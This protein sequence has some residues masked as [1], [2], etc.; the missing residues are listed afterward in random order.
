M[1]I[2]LSPETQKLLEERMKRGRFATPDDVVRVALE[3]LEQYEGDA[4]E[5]LEP[6]TLAAIE[7]A[8]AQ[9]VRG[10]GRP[11]EEVKAELRAKFLQG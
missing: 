5:D 3:M 7:R 6:D 11:W 10:E 1:T 8:E 2:S 4:L 9:S